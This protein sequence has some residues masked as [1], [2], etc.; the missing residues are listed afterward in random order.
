MSYMHFLLLSD[1]G[2]LFQTYRLQSAVRR[3]LVHLEPQNQASEAQSSV[4]RGEGE[5]ARWLPGAH[6]LRAVREL[7]LSAWIVC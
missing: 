7:S 3:L 1:A 6:L 2:A 4:R 5:P